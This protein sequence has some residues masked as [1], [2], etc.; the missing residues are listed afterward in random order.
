[1]RNPYASSPVQCWHYKNCGG[2]HV[3]FP[4]LKANYHISKKLVVNGRRQVIMGHGATPS[5]AVKNALRT[6][7]PWNWKKYW[8]SKESHWYRISQEWE[9]N[10]QAH[11]R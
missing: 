4:L 6:F 2:F 1:M 8:Q 3:G 7:K 10:R 9:G 5:E 11:D